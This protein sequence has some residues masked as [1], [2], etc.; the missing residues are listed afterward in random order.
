MLIGQVQT[1][2]AQYQPDPLRYQSQIIAFEEQ[3]LANPPDENAVLLV[4]GLSI[5]FWT[6]AITELSP[7]TAINRGFG[8]SV[9]N[10]VIYYFDRIIAKYNP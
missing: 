3:D 4:G 7:G 5:R 9:M 1:N 10:V 8:G 2:F 6:N